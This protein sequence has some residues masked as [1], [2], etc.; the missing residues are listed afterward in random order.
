[1]QYLL[2]KFRETRG[3]VLN[4]NPEGTTNVVLELEA[5]TYYVTLVPPYDF[6]PSTQV[7]RLKD[8]SALKPMEVEFV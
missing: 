1:M 3:V 4:G 6:T 8:T 2:V 7:I 5:G